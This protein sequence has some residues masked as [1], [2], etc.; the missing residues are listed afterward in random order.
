[1]DQDE[2]KVLQV[3]VLEPYYGGSHK[4]FLKGL[5]RLPYTFDFMTLPARK[6][7][8]RMRLALCSRSFPPDPEAAPTTDRPSRSAPAR[9]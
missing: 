4:A 5:S 2:K 3:L 8:W 6:W 1:M 7:K 9:H